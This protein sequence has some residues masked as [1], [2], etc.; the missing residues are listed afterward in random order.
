MKQKY[1]VHVSAENH[2]ALIA[3]LAEES[4]LNVKG[5]RGADTGNSIVAVVEGRVTILEFYPNKTVV[6]VAALIH[7]GAKD[8]AEKII[9]DASMRDYGQFDYAMR[10]IGSYALA[11]IS[12]YMEP[13]AVVAE[14]VL[15]EMMGCL[16]D[17]FV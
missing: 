1:D 15:R 3:E 14:A 16:D 5:L 8:A 10:E 7:P 6:H 2:A 17:L 12:L 11:V 13:D 9:H 4:H